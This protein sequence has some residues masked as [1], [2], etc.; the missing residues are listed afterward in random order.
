MGSAA[1]V[2]RVVLTRH[3][4]H[5]HHFAALPME[6]QPKAC[7]DPGLGPMTHF[8]ITHTLATVGELPSTQ[9]LPSGLHL[10]PLADKCPSALAPS[11]LGS[12]SLLGS[13]NPLGLRPYLGLCLRTLSSRLPALGPCYLLMSG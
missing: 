3:G 9:P 5:W 7:G 4:T 1:K 8:P 10:V 13:M 11:S 2:P 6:V 12:A